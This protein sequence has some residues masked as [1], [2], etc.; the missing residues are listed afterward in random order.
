MKLTEPVEVNFIITFPEKA[1]SYPKTRK[2]EG[3]DDQSDKE[4]AED[5]S[6]SY[7][8]QEEEQ[9]ALLQLRKTT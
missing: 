5:R 6:Q 1:E 4:T 7:E 3:Q 8:G 2:G 9:S